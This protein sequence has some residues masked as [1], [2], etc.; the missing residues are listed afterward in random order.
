MIAERVDIA[1]V[2]AGIG[3]LAA[4]VALSRTGW[5]VAVYEQAQRFERV[6]AGLQ[7]A[8]N[9]TAALR[10]LGLLPAV[11][12]RANRPQAWR[13][14]DAHSGVVCREEELG[15][16]MVRRYGSPYLH[17]HR[18]DLHEA[19]L[20]EAHRLCPVHL[21][22][23]LDGIEQ[24]PSG[25]L[26]RFKDGSQGFAHT[27]IGADGIHS[28]VRQILFGP[29]Q[30]RFSEMVAYR[31]LVPRNRLRGQ[32]I[33]PEAAKWWAC[34][35]HLV[36]YW[37]SGG[38][39]L[40]YVAPVPAPEWTQ[41]SWSDSGSVDD[42]VTALADFVPHI[43]SLV[44]ESSTLFR[45]ALFDRDPLPAWG[46]GQITLL[47]DAAH[48]MLPFMAQGS[49]MAVED[50]VVLARVLHQGEIEDAPAAFSTY[51][52][53]RKARTTAIQAGSRANTFL[54][55][56]TAAV[57]EP[58]VP[59]PHEV[60]AYDAWRVPILGHGPQQEAGQHIGTR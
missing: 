47:G 31:G 1:I 11:Q 39:E 24:T 35:R 18:S 33:A 5:S 40:N 45:S 42:L 21:G 4:A 2:G 19:L 29:A 17:V 34:D 48:P 56:R 25:L 60:Y 50:A 57:D 49:A 53:A 20:R 38:R 43:R 51:E 32:N 30:A 44:R 12:A 58:A 41:E 16:A 23:R 15:D 59:T 3:G 13:S 28:T 27:L 14:Y 6:G 36:H 52:Q 54:R 8:P 7:L 10:G 26:L 55:E 46:E 22:R 9:A 37:I